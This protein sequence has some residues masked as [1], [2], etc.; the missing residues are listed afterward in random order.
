MLGKETLPMKLKKLAAAVLIAF[1]ATTF[2]VSV[3]CAA[4]AKAPKVKESKQTKQLRSQ[5]QKIMHSWIRSENRRDSDNSQTSYVE[6]EA[7]FFSPEYIEAHV[8]DQAQLNLWTE[9][10]LEDYKYKY[11]QTLQLDKMIPFLIHIDNS[12]EAMH[13]APFD[14]I[15]KMRVGSKTYKPVDYDKRFNFRL[16][17]EIEGLVFFPRYDEKTGKPLIPEKGGTVQLEFNSFMS[18][19]LKS[20]INL[21]WSLGNQDINRLYQGKT[22]A[23]L[24]SDRML[25]RL[26]K[27]RKEKEAIDAKAGTMQQEIDT[28]QKRLDELQK[29]Q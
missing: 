25:E 11:L 13:M 23:R 10:E 19:I 28:I 2:A 18:P 22:A 27:V 12:A 15:V 3:C 20:N 7:A 29:Q 21:M 8:Q 5:F 1:I 26:E 17:G 9:Q 6:V 4:A 14:N 24:E 16:M